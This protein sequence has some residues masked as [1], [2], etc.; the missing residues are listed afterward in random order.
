MRYNGNCLE[1]SAEREMHSKKEVEEA[2][3]KESEKPLNI[4][5][6]RERLRD[7][8]TEDNMDNN[9]GKRKIPALFWFLDKMGN[10]NRTK[11]SGN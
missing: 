2:E 1:G 9:E 3:S 5:E 10:R 11:E 7:S 6:D 8:K 4:D